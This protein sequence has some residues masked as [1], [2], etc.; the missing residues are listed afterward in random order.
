MGATH[1]DET[2]PLPGPKPYEMI[3]EFARAQKAEDPYSFSFEPQEY[4]L[5]MKGGVTRSARFP[6]SE[7]LLEDLQTLTWAKSAPE[8]AKRLG[9]H[10]RRF[11]D[12]LDWGGH[13]HVLERSGRTPGELRVVIRSAAAELYALP[14]ELVTLKDSGQHLADLLGCTVSYEWPTER[15]GLMRP[16]APENVRLL[17]AW[18]VAGGL[19]PTD[20]H[21][22]TLAKSCQKAGVA[23]DEQRDTL[24]NVSLSRLEERLSASPE[25]ISVL[26]VLCHGAPLETK[27]SGAYG[28]M[29]NSSEEGADKELVDGARLGALLAPYADTL[30]MVV[31]CACHG[32]DGGKLASH[33]GSVAQELHRV[34]IEAVV[35]SRLPLSLPGSVLMTETMYQKL[36]VESLSLEEAL[37]A[38]RRRLR[39]AGNGFD[40]ATLQ[41]YARGSQRFSLGQGKPPKAP[42]IPTSPR[43]PGNAVSLWRRSFLALSTRAVGGDPSEGVMTLAAKMASL[44]G[45]PVRSEVTLRGTVNPDGSI[46]PVDGLHP[47]V[48][49]IY[50]AYELLTEQKLSQPQPVDSSAMSPSLWVMQRMQVKTSMLMAQT[51]SNLAQLKQ[52]NPYTSDLAPML[53]LADAA[54]TQAAHYRTMGMVPAAYYRAHDAAARANAALNHRAF[55]DELVNPGPMPN[56]QDQFLQTLRSLITD[57]QTLMAQL[58]TEQAWC[59]PHVMTLLGTHESALLALAE[60]QV[61]TAFLEQCSQVGNLYKVTPSVQHGQ[62]FIDLT[63]TVHVVLSQARLNVDA[64]AEVQ[65]FCAEQERHIKQGAPSL[66]Q[67]AQAYASAAQANLDS[68]QALLTRLEANQPGQSPAP[69]PIPNLLLTRALMDRTLL[70]LQRQEPA[71]F[72]LASAQSSYLHSAHFLTNL[73][74]HV[75][76]QAKPANGEAVQSHRVFL[77]MLELAEHK[78]R[79][80]AAAAREAIGVVPVQAQLAYQRACTQREGDAGDKWEALRSFWSASLASQVAVALTQS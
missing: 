49:D 25:P 71:L 67:L 45:V 68:I 78:A 58:A 69:M 56:Q 28:L 76:D 50:E 66:T 1:L 10:L 36:L 62:Q 15:E 31:L 13:E 70:G 41:F 24:P 11:L 12:E 75:L 74:L 8:A 39:V 60:L 54:Y 63:A 20:R 61:V 38:A 32:G 47:E 64:C 7:H 51:W 30:K 46:G 3:L 37:S 18:S 5:R 59:I 44:Q 42:G 34:G 57:M 27:E 4:R 22:Q 43:S 48:R 72:C 55:L 80:F 53:G 14:W 35:A 26:H 16:P 33:L 79:E 29:W 77:A 19:V 6:W 52:P 40:W 2:R 9:E 17:F 65:E 73:N 21:Q 23:F